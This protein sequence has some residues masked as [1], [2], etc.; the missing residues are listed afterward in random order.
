M[1]RGAKRTAYDLDTDELIVA[2]D[3]HPLTA[4]DIFPQRLR[5]PLVVWAETPERA[6]PNLFVGCMPSPTRVG[7]G[8]EGPEGVLAARVPRLAP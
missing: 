6:C 5:H 2:V 7:P 4:S 8:L 1:H 3:G